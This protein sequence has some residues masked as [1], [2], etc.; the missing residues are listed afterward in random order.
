MLNF[1]PLCKELYKEWVL[2]KHQDGELT[3]S[4]VDWFQV[5]TSC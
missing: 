5:V 1:I 4:L 3:H 2:L